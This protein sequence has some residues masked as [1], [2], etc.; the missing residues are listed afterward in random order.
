MELNKHGETCGC[1]SSHIYV[2]VERILLLVRTIVHSL[3]ESLQESSSAGRFEN[4]WHERRKHTPD[5]PVSDGRN[6]KL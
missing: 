2:L 1:D 6:C 3:T 5:I 4:E